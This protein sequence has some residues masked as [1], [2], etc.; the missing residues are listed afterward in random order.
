MKKE[1][2]RRMINGEWRLRTVRMTCLNWEMKTGDWKIE[3][4]AWLK[5]G[6][7]R[8]EEKR[9]LIKTKEMKKEW[10]RRMINGEWRLRTMRMTCLNWEMK[11]RDWKIEEHAWLKTGNW[12]NEE[13]RELIKTKEMKKE[14]IRRMLNDEWRLRTMRTTCLN[15][16]MKTEDWKIEEH[17]WLK[18]DN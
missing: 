7:W 13:K 4:H 15:W 14:W 16:E 8:N 17:A 3:E 9:E 11:T 12:R 2:I 1:W 6:N 5:T 10:I 18:T